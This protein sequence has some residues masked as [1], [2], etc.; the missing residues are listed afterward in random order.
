VSEQRFVQ[1][2]VFQLAPSWRPLSEEER[3]QGRAE[4]VA[5]L[6]SGAAPV[7]TYSYSLVGLK[8]GADLLLWRISP[9]LEALQESVSRL[10]QTG[11][12]RRLFIAHSLLG[13]T[14]PSLYVRKPDLQEQAVFASNR[15]RYGIIYPFTKTADWYLLSK[16]ARQGMMN[17]HIRVGK[18]FPS[19]RQALV[20]SFGLDDQEFIVFYETEQLEDF[21]SLVMALRETEAR[22]YTLKD[23]P[24]FVGVHRPLEETLALLG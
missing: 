5:A 7:T 3:R 1:F 13:L 18:E 19:V 15:S 24:I 6:Q 12:G 10:L 2:L 17:E 21:Q 22:R 11:L 16:E 20:Y 9:S 23:T 14:R 8:S 4:F